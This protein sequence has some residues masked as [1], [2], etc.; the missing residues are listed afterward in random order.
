M[1]LIIKFIVFIVFAILISGCIEELGQLEQEEEQEQ[2]EVE[3]EKPIGITNISDATEILI[4][5]VLEP[6]SMGNAVTYILPDPLQKGDV[7]RPQVSDGLKEHVIENKT[8]FAFV[9]DDPQETF[10]HPVRYVFID[11]TTREHKVVNEEWWPTIN[12]VSIWDIEDSDEG[13]LNAIYA[14]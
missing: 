7:V 11:A 9:D 3:V 12:N 2:K 13:G 4:G 10:P 6:G 5:N 14:I 8:W 1:K